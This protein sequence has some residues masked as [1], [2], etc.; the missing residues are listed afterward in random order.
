VRRRSD[1]LSVDSAANADSGPVHAWRFVTGAGEQ[2]YL[3]D[4]AGL[5]LWGF[6]RSSRT[7]RQLQDPLSEAAWQLIAQVLAD[8]DRVPIASP[9]SA[10]NRAIESPMTLSDGGTRGVD[11]TTHRPGHAV[12]AHLAALHAD[13][14]AGGPG[15]LSDDF[16]SFSVGFVGEEIVGA[17][18]ARLGAGWHV[19]HA[20][21]VGA[22]S[23]DI[24]HVLIGPSGVYTINSKHHP[25]GRLQTKGGDTVFLGQTWKPYARKSVAEAKRATA[26]LATSCGFPGEA[27]A[28]IAVVGARLD[29]RLPLD[30]VVVVAEDQLV[31]WL[32]NQPQTLTPAQVEHVF[33]AARWSRTWSNTP[34]VPVAPEWIAETARAVAADHSIAQYSRGRAASTIGR[35][36]PNTRRPVSRRSTTTRGPA[37]AR[38]GSRPN[39]RQ[40]SIHSDLKR[41]L[42]GLVILIGLL[43]FAKP[44]A[45][46]IEGATSVAV[47]NTVPAAKPSAGTS[48]STLG[49]KSVDATNT[50]IACGPTSGDPA[51]LTWQRK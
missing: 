42:A 36:A 22:G 6:D 2:I 35:R 44:L 1:A 34:P 47:S 40:T 43:V 37:A 15:E 21:P 32:R 20:V 29:A 9:P 30:H 46:A 31:G 8:P 33:A 10:G 14:T 51:N 49:A 48:C 39:R 45:H 50:A 7:P 13:A 38:V 18:L 41:Q 26:L 27:R 19:L 23:T 11:L 28:V 12:L 17:E 3:Y 16:V 25:G 5:P 4:A 24:D